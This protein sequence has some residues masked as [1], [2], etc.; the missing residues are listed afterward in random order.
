MSEQLWDEVQAELGRRAAAEGGA[1]F[2]DRP[3]R[4]R[5]SFTVRCEQGHVSTRVL[6]TDRGDRCLACQSRVTLTFPEDRDG[7]LGSHQGVEGE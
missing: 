4:W 3:D 1:M 7:P 6:G 5:E 2:M